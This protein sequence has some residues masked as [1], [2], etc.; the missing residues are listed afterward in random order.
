MKPT[1]PAG[2]RYELDQRPLLP[3]FGGRINGHFDPGEIHPTN[4][5]PVFLWWGRPTAAVLRWGWKNSWNS[6]PVLNARSETASTHPNFQTAFLARRC[7]IPATAW[8]EAKT[9]NGRKVLHRF[10]PLDGGLM[11]IAGLWAEDVSAA[12][13]H[14]FTML[15]R[16]ADDMFSPITQRMPLVLPREAWLAWIDPGTSDPATLMDRARLNEWQVP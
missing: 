11:G 9:S 13:D 14:R 2:T 7:I 4:R 15:T 1:G 10:R 6:Q 12:A 5:A 8:I 3:E 16:E